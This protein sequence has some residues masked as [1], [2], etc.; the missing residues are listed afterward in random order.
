VNRRR[1]GRIG[2]WLALAAVGGTGVLVLFRTWSPLQQVGIR[3]VAV[4]GCS[5][6]LTALLVASALV[7]GAVAA[8]GR[9]P[10]GARWLLAASVPLVAVVQMTWPTAVGLVRPEDPG[11][12]P[13]LRIAA[14]NLWKDNP[15]PRRAAR[16]VLAARADVLVLT[17]L[18]PR[19]LQALRREGMERAYPYRVVRTRRGSGG[20]AVLSKVLFHLPRGQTSSYRLEV[21]LRPQGAAPVDLVAAHL[22]SPTRFGV[23]GWVDEYRDLTSFVAGRGTD[24]VLA[25]DFNATSGT[26]PFRA[27][28]SAGNLRDA[29]DVGG[30]GFRPTWSERSR[31]P[32]LLRLD[33]VL[34]GA[35]TG[36]ASF[37]FLAP[38]GSDHR[39][40]VADLRLRRPVAAP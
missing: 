31:L 8:W 35:A 22:P 32:P 14:Q 26:I 15:D 10:G 21:V 11:P 4:A 34:V 37:R 7:G 25:G 38:I 20:I 39:G 6:V 23:D 17:E 30:G 29:Q 9:A 2:T 36:V 19:L 16:T 5:D 18:T 40:I 1:A 33:H 28:A 3:S 12:G 27:L 13:G 24:L